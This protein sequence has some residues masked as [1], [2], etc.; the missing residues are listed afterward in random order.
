M[1]LQLKLLHNGNRQVYIKNKPAV[2]VQGKYLTDD[3][4]EKYGLEH[5]SQSN[6]DSSD[7]V[8]TIHMDVSLFLRLLELAR[9]S[10]LD[11]V[12]LHQIAQGVTEL[13]KK[14]GLLQISQYKDIVNYIK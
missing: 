10:D 8:D 11:D 9:E 14:K 7:V 3:I 5:N 4:I 13:S 12:N 2:V 6:S 1:I